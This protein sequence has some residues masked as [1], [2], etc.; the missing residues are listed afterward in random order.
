MAKP[1]SKALGVDIGGSGVKGA[2]VH[3]KR[4]ELLAE[5]H[6]IPTPRPATPK[7]VAGAVVEV[8]RFFGWTGPIGCTVPALVRNGVVESASNMDPSWV[9]TRAARLFKKATGCPVAVINDADAAGLAEMRYGAGKGRKGVTLV[10]TIGTGI[11]SALFLDGR[12]VPNTEFGHLQFAESIAEHHASDRVREAHGMRWQ[13][14]AEE[15]LQPVLAHIEFVLSPDLIIIGGGVSR[16]ERWA[17]FG[18]L[19]RTRAELVPAALGNDAGIVGAGIAARAQIPRKRK[20]KR[21]AS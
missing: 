13:V 19:L 2:P 11:G 1:L 10:L 20:K 16:P 17:E 6:R 14:W 12:L 21:A 9:G 8:A 18:H 15:R 3:L 5:R 4:G 7:A